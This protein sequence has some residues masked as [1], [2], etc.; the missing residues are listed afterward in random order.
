MLNCALWSY[1]KRNIDT[2]YRFCCAD[3]PYTILQNILSSIS[4]RLNRS[5]NNSAFPGYH[6]HYFITSLSARE[7]V[8]EDEEKK[9]FN[10][11]CTID[12]RYLEFQGTLWNTSRYPY[13]DISDFQNRGKSNSNKPHLTNIYAV[14]LLTL[15]IYR[16]YCRKEEKFHNIF[17][18][19]LGFHV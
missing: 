9:R 11:S 3:R 2:K 6:L 15:G 16:K 1:F 19:L 13:L 12:S 14:G 4:F 17:Y 5:I 10:I 7:E 8:K 18:L